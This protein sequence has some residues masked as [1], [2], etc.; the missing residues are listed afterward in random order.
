MEKFDRGSGDGK[1]S[2][3]QSLD[4]ERE[5]KERD[6]DEEDCGV[7]SFGS[8]CRSSSLSSFF[9]FSLLFI[10]CGDFFFDKSPPNPLPVPCS[11][12]FL[13]CRL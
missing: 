8:S 3:P 13:Y 6:D 9:F 2:Y 5:M 10:D 12:A 7:D 1:I 11:L 4:R